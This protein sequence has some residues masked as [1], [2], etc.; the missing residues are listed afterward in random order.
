[1][2][3]TVL[4]YLEEM[5]EYSCGQI[6]FGEADA[7][8]MCQL[9]YLKYD[10]LV[11]GIYENKSSV[12]IRNLSKS[13]RFHEIFEDPFFE[14][15]NKELYKR[16]VNSKRFGY[17]RIN[18]YVDIYDTDREIQFCAMTFLVPEGPVFIAFRG[19]DE[20]LAGWKEN[21]N[22]SLEAP[23]PCQ[24]YSAVYLNMIAKKI[25]GKFLVGGHSKG[26]NLAVY[27]ASKCFTEIQNR[28][29][30]IYCL[31]GPGFSSRVLEEG[32]YNNT[33]KK[34]V[35]L[36]PAYSFIGRLFEKEYRG[37]TIKSR[38]LGLMQHDLFTWEI[39]E[40]KFVEEKHGIHEST[41]LD[42]GI[43]QWVGTLSYQERK[44][45]CDTIYKLLSEGGIMDLNA[46]TAEG[47]NSMLSLA[48][49]IRKMDR[50]TMITMSKMICSLFEILGGLLERNEK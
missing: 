22:M 13:P 45:F 12:C 14:K 23:V 17:L 32:L 34:T 40:G 21:M 43:N 10:C 35:K 7:L 18:G 31:D 24:K 36:L 9:A 11:P 42:K 19:T 20:T 47:K 25:Q 1:M 3:G 15:Q 37:R 27:G 26:G 28:I 39:K 50:C 46:F 41:I 30:T 16:V 8:V 44:L 29:D 5:G 2:A 38:G 6:P 49:I 4:E 48:G 33:M